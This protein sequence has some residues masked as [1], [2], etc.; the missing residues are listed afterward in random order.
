MTAEHLAHGSKKMQTPLRIAIIASALALGGCPRTISTPATE[1]PS[2]SKDLGARSNDWPTV[3]TRSGESHK[4]QG[5]ID[6]IRIIHAR[7]REPIDLLFT[8]SIEGHVLQVTDS[9]GSRTYSMAEQPHIE[10]DYRDRKGGRTAGGIAL[11][12]LGIP[13]MVGGVSALVEASE[14][15]GGSGLEGVAAPFAGVAGALLISLGICSAGPGIYLL[16]TDPSKP[17]ADDY[18]SMA[19][20]VHVGPQGVGLSLKF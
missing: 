9:K 19:P 16:A 6:S 8:A 14:L 11:I 13:F 18:A 12:G 5:P 15:K 2:L 10:I 7:G 4:I 1:L 3:T 17:Q 20:T